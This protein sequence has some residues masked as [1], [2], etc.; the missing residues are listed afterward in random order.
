MGWKDYLY[1]TS[2]VI[3][4][5][6]SLKGLNKNNIKIALKDKGFYINLLFIG[7]APLL[8]LI[9]LLLDK[10]YIQKQKNNANTL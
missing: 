1:Y 3:C 10:F 9:L 8:S 5:V 6:W 2:L 7:V 4:L